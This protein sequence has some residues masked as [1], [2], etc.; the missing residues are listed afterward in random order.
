MDE[1][2]VDPRLRV[3][4][5]IQVC[6]SSMSGKSSIC[7]KIILNKE[8]LFKKPPEIIIW[9]Y[10]EAQD[11]HEELM[12]RPDVIF[13]KDIE[14]IY[15]YMDGTQ[16]VMIIVDDRITS[17]LKNSH[18]IIKL[19]VQKTH[20]YQ[21]IFVLVLHA[22]FVKDLRLANLQTSYLVITKLLRDYSSVY[23]LSYQLNPLNPKLVYSAYEHTARRQKYVDFCI[24]LHSENDERTR[25]RSSI[26]FWEDATVFI[27][28]NFI[29]Y[30]T[31][32]L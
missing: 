16:V 18:D 20:H 24:C 19:M 12:N 8:R 9:V 5:S 32:K 7:K 15:T 29:Q 30:N 17:I 2:P 1:L 6:G 31:A 25:Y 27:P 22:I 26:F 21:L 14:D 23:R 10:Q 28:T 11:L 13:T 4:C 3:P